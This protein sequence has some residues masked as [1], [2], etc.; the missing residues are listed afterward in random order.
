[1]GKLLSAAARFGEANRE[2]TLQYEEAA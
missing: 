2:E 1:M